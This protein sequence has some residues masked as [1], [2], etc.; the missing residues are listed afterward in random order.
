MELLGRT[1]RRALDAYAH[2]DVPFERLVNALEP[3]RQL[4]RT[5]LF[6]VMFALQNAPQPELRLGGLE[7]TPLAAEPGT[8]KFDLTLSLAAGAEGLSGGVEYNTDLFEQATI[9]RLVRSLAAGAGGR[10]GRSAASG[11][12][13]A[14]AD[15]RRSCTGSWCSGTPRPPT[16]PAAACVHELFEAQAA[17]TPAAVALV[18][19]EQ[20]LTY[21]ELNGRANQLARHLRRLGVGA[22]TPV[23]LCVERSPEM[24]VAILGVLKAGGAYVPL[25]PDYPPQRLEFMLRDCRAPVLVTQSSLVERLPGYSGRIVAARPTRPISTRRAP[26]TCPR[27]PRPRTSPTSSTPPGP[28]ARPRASRCAHARRCNLVHGHGGVSAHA[29]RSRRPGRRIGFDASVWEILA[30]LRPAAG[31]YLPDQDALRSCRTAAPGVADRHGA[32]R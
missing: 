6:Q 28:P 31:L 14:A 10:G 17:R 12:A 24:V 7:V 1:R 16:Y 30:R 29:G 5:P 13:A 9:E 11:A 27:P 8:A 19:E 23:A 3:Q 2:Q 20:T 21:A 22:D 26:P 32:S 4:N 25:D 18:F 15:A